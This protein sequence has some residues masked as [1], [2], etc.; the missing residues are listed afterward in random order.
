M[1]N[2]AV[3]V[4]QAVEDFIHD[5]QFPSSQAVRLPKR[6]RRS[7]QIFLI[8]IHFLRSQAGLVEPAQAS[9]KLL[10]DVDNA[11][12]PNLGRVRCKYRRDHSFRKQVA[13]IFRL[14]P[15]GS[16]NGKRSGN[17]PRHGRFAID[18][19]EALRSGV[20]SVFCDVHELRELAERADHALQ[21][22]RRHAGAEGSKIVVQTRAGLSAA[23][24]RQT[25]DLFHNLADLFA[26]AGLNSLTQQSAEKPNVFDQGSGRQASSLHA[27]FPQL[28]MQMPIPCAN[29]SIGWQDLAEES[30]T[31]AIGHE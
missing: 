8:S 17:R 18:D 23:C 28:K 26:V 31:R 20:M 10:L 24:R 13:D 22:A 16:Q 5:L 12:A 2:R 11:L 9:C 1:E 30:R 29:V 27:C 21:S 25:A 6:G 14:Y 4:G 15:G 7:F 19:A 3:I